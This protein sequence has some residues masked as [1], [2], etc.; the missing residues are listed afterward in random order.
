MFLHGGSPAPPP[1]FTPVAHIFT[2]VAPVFTP[3]APVFTTADPVFIP[4][5]PVFIPPAP[6]FTPAAPVFTPAAPVFNSAPS[7]FTPADPVFTLAAPLHLAVLSSISPHSFSP[8]KSTW[9][10]F[11]SEEDNESFSVISDSSYRVHRVS[12]FRISESA[13]L[14][15]NRNICN[16][17]AKPNLNQPIIHDTDLV[18][19]ILKEIALKDKKLADKLIYFHPFILPL[20]DVVTC[21]ERVHQAR[22]AAGQGRPAPNLKTPFV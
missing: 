10:S 2:P 1:V 21:R 20:R 22:G 6:V 3:A 17:I 11:P 19:G 16:H 8:T 9:T 18:H 4:A 14:V 7:V 13:T 15:L 12:I 5:A